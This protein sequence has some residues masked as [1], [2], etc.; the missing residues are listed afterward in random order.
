MSY[1]LIGNG[2]NIANNN[3]FIDNNNVYERFMNNFKAKFI[4]FKDSLY[5]NDIEFRE[6]EELIGVYRNL[7]IEQVTGYIFEYLAKAIIE[8]NGELSWNA[9]YRLIELLAA[10]SLES[11]FIVDGN[12]MYPKVSYKYKEKLDSYDY[13]L[14]LNY[15]EEWD[16][17]NK[18]LYLHGNICKY[19]NSYQGQM[20]I[21]SILKHTT[22]IKKYLNKDYIDIDIDDVI[23]VPSNKLVDKHAYVGEGLF[24]NKCGLNVYPADDLFPSDGKGDIYASLNSVEKIEIFGVSPFGEKSLIEKLTTIKEVII[25][26]YR[27]DE[28]EIKEWKKYIPN[29]IIKNSQDFLK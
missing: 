14:T 9:C 8:K 7:G 12:V 16:T 2:L 18:C 19:L 4:L 20:I 27:D 22:E 5:L 23:F 28:K 24:C 26:V 11:L 15:V 29:A 6:I 21:T 25:Y 1:L 17:Y 13:I 10:L 3:S